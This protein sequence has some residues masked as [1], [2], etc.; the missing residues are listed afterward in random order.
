MAKDDTR[1]HILDTAIDLFWAQSYH[2]VNMNALS[3]KA[4]VNKATVYQYFP[5]KEALA[6]AAIRRASERTEDYVYRSTFAETDDPKE[7]LERIYQKVFWMHEGVFKADGKCRG[8]P[9]VNIGV[10]MS[11]SSEAI[12]KAV[13]QAFASIETYYDQIVD[14]HGKL[15]D[16]FTRNETVAT[17]IAN[18][19]AAL[20][21]SKLEN[22][23][24]AIKDGQRRALQLL[25][26]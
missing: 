17:L 4:G 20:V 24:G 22:R 14:D 7:R 9:F 26:M 15:P 16:G 6:V 13:G 8:C 12:R 10:E 3:R 18:M 21:A 2:G 1:N 23:P 19:N 11:T 25:A 5:S